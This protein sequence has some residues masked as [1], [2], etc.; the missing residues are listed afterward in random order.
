MVSIMRSPCIYGLVKQQNPQLCCQCPFL[1]FDIQCSLHIILPQ[2]EGII[3]AE[4][5][6]TTRWWGVRLRELW[7]WVDGWSPNTDTSSRDFMSLYKVFTRLARCC[8]CVHVFWVH[9]CMHECAWHGS[10]FWSSKSHCNDKEETLWIFTTRISISN[11]F[12]CRLA[13]VILTYVP[14]TV[15]CHFSQR[16]NR[17][18]V[19]PLIKFC[20]IF[21]VIVVTVIG[22]G[23]RKLWCDPV[24]FSFWVSQYWIVTE[25]HE[26]M[27]TRCF[28]QRKK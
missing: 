9:M 8:M 12:H 23:R 10:A 25:V 4:T 17:N 19:G 11:L 22:L 2:N 21:N 28:Q 7:N 14:P 18:R 3:E 27:Q 1:W 15:T 16:S 26:K 13:H 20:S 6:K 24:S 5:C